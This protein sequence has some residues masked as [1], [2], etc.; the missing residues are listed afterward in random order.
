MASS[1]K[2]AIM[3]YETMGF[4]EDLIA[5]LKKAVETRYEG[6]PS[7]LAR[8]ADTHVSTLTRLLEGERKQWLHLIARIADSAGVKVT[9]IE[10]G[11]DAMTA[12][13]PD[14]EL[15]Q[16]ID[17]LTR[18]R[19]ALISA[20]KALEKNIEYMNKIAEMEAQNNAGKKGENFAQNRPAV[21]SVEDG[22]GC[23]R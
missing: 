19:D 9:L 6:K 22:A 4:Y 13:T 5:C 20:N 1:Q 18:E 21:P 3:I 11:R 10:T 12:K 16:K 8:A 15:Q 2:D 7:R 14:S 17:A 23:G